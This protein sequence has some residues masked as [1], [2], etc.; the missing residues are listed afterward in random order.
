MLLLVN[1]Y[2]YD[3]ASSIAKGFQQI[4]IEPLLVFGISEEG[5]DT[6]LINNVVSV[7]NDWLIG[8][9]MWI[10]RKVIIFKLFKGMR[11]SRVILECEVAT[12]Q[13]QISMTW[14]V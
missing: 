4:I 2:R 11:E 1:H 3:L 9:S 6:T 8:I 14:L 12:S 10:P 13:A 7:Q 5:K